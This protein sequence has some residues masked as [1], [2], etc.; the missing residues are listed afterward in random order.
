MEKYED[1]FNPSFLNNEKDNRLAIPKDAAVT[2]AYIPL[3]ESLEAYSSDK[4]LAK[5]TLFPEL[6]KVFEGRMVKK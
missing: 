2:M 5:G 4:A 6:N 3:Q 1:L